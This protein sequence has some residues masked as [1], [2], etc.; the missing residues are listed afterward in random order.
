[1]DVL[2]QPYSG[3]G[4]IFSGSQNP[5]FSWVPKPGFNLHPV[6]L[7]GEAPPE[8]GTFFRLQLHQRVGISLSDYT[9]NLPHLDYRRIPHLVKMFKRNLL[10]QYQEYWSKNLNKG[11]FDSSVGNKLSLYSELKNEV[12]FESYLDLTKNVKTRVAIT[13]M[14]ISCPLLPI[15]LI[16]E[17]QEDT[18][19]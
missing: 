10:K 16:W 19:S 15:E 6:A 4:G 5:D 11:K 13:K 14:R 3:E 12:R 17:L 7:Y 9:P 1:M 2:V 18:Q 8:R